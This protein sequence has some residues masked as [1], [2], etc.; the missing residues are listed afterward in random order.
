[1]SERADVS[2]FFYNLGARMS[3]PFPHRHI[4]TDIYQ[5][6]NSGTV[7]NRK[8]WTTLSRIEHSPFS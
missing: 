5:V 8:S 2:I 1:M 6:I 7:K 4:H 3:I